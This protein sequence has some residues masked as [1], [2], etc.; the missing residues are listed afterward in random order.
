MNRRSGISAKAKLQRIKA[1]HEQQRKTAQDAALKQ[2]ELK[3]RPVDLITLS[4]QVK[5]AMTAL[6]GDFDRYIGRLHQLGKE[7]SQLVI[8]AKNWCSLS[9]VAKSNTL[10]YKGIPVNK[11]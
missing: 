3:N 1:Q 2:L 10:T 6:F 4:A 7:P 11:R 8:P 5:P 9:E